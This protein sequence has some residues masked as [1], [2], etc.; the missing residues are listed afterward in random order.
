MH[1]QRRRRERRLHRSKNA[2][3]CGRA[4]GL[5]VLDAVAAGSQE[6]EKT[7]KTGLLEPFGVGHE[8]GV[9]ADVGVGVSDGGGGD[10]DGATEGAQ[11]LET[12]G[13]GRLRS[14]TR[15]IPFA[16]TPMI[17][18]PR[19]ETLGASSLVPPVTAAATAAAAA[20][21]KEAADSTRQEE[22]EEKEEREQDA[23]LSSSS[24]PTKSLDDDDGRGGRTCPA[25]FRELVLIMDSTP[26][27]E[28]RQKLPGL[29]EDID[30][31][32]YASFDAIS[33]AA[34]IVG[35]FVAGVNLSIVC[36]TN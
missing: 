31:S 2:R 19:P 24:V 8:H 20:A 34:F 35:S 17:G 30:V 22:E 29:P 6:D 28:P 16:G 27:P 32:L 33:V 25:M 36:C 18:K 10:G 14:A 4:G 7:E 1:W 13:P 5:H 26:L 3:K 12:A 9:A 23:L 15:P 11:A 21:E